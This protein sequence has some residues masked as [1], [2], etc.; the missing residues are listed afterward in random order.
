MVTQR[1]DD[2]LICKEYQDRI[3]EVSSDHPGFIT[4]KHPN[5]NHYFAWVND[6][7]VVLRSE[8]YPDEEKMLR[9]INAIKKNWDLTERYSV[10]SQHGVHFL[11]L[12]GGGNHEAH[13]GNME[14]HNEIGRSCPKKTREELHAL[15]LHK[16]KDFAQKVVPIEE[17]KAAAAPVVEAEA[18][19]APV[20]DDSAEKAKAAAAAAAA[21]AAAASFSATEKKPTASTP[22]VEATAA[23]RVETRAAAAVE[24]SSGGFKWWYLLPLLLLPILYMKMCNKPAA[25]EA[26]PV[27]EVVVPTETAVV[28]TAK[29][30][31]ATPAAT[32]AATPDCNLNWILFDFDKYAI[33][34]SANGELKTM[35]DI[36]KGNPDYVGELSAHTDA[37]GSNEYNDVLSNNRAKAAKATLVGMGIDAGRLTTSASSEGAPIATNTDDDAGR[38]YNRRVELRVKDKSG[39]EIC[40]SIPPNVPGELKSK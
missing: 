30:V 29:A 6:G 37:K 40:K 18:A 33:T 25:V 32:P 16:G 19:P 2:Y 8:A 35:A 20:V 34:P 15:L 14:S 9:G 11:V 26:P 12:W 3:G 17:I 13:T 22:R 28:D 7:H 24:E 27:E 21:T 1:D 4:F 23:P 36:L 31:K 10:D 5:N 39:K 38:K